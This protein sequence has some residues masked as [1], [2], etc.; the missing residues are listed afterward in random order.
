ML[1]FIFP[2][3]GTQTP[4]M[5]DPWSTHPAWDIAQMSQEH[6]GLDVPRLLRSAVLFELER[7]PNSQVAVTT[8][9]L[10]SW[11]AVIDAGVTPFSSPG[12]AS[13]STPRLQPAERSIRH[14]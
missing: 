1:G 11:Q 9:S 4:A 13:A 6:T 8:L 7:T 5:G 12:T 10:M 2:G 14:I 3:Q